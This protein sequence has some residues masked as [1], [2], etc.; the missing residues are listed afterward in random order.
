MVI[1]GFFLLF[2]FAELFFTIIG[3]IFEGFFFVVGGLFE[4][5][6]SFIG[7]IFEGIFIGIYHLIQLTVGSDSIIL[8]KMGKIKFPKFKRKQKIIIKSSKDLHI[9]MEQDEITINDKLD[10]LFDKEETK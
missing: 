5:L 6:F 3:A 7:M 10:K 1:G 8:K 9:K 2:L 4:L